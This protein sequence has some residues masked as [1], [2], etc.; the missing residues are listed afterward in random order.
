MYAPKSS[1]SLS[2]GCGFYW[3][4][5]LRVAKGQEF[6]AKIETTLLRLPRAV[7]A[8]VWGWCFKPSLSVTNLQVCFTK[9][10]FLLVL[11]K[12]QFHEVLLSGLVVSVFTRY[13][14]VGCVVPSS[15]ISDWTLWVGA[16]KVQSGAYSRTTSASSP[17]CL[18]LYN[19][20]AH[21]L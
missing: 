20:E 16:N 10:S 13:T 1:T 3:T 18:E 6:F 8:L 19:R 12:H 15:E 9:C 17:G 21:S 14:K 11:I 5:V 7:V 4:K 2:G